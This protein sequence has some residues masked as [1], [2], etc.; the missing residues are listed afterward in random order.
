[1]TKYFHFAAI[2]SLFMVEPKIEPKVVG[3]LAS[4]KCWSKEER[5]ANLAPQLMMSH[6]NFFMFFYG[7]L[8]AHNNH[9]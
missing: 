7:L 6:C 8:Q 1:M 5:V 9:L 3:S 4:A 2:L